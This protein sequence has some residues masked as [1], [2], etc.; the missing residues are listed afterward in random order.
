[1]RA[2]LRPVQSFE[3]LA[4]FEP[5]SVDRDEKVDVRHRGEHR[6]GRH[7]AAFEIKP[8][9]RRRLARV[10]AQVVKLLCIAQ[11]LYGKRCAAPTLPG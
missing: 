10:I 7:I 8:G 1:M 3:L 2:G 5:G 11:P 6:P 9:V 4:G